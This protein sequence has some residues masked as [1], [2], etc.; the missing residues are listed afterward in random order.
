M[1]LGAL[2]PSM[3]IMILRQGMI[4]S[5]AGLALGMLA[6]A[7]VG[8]LVQGTFP[9]TGTDAVTFL[10][11]VPVVALVVMLATYIPARRA[12]RIDPLAA[13]RQE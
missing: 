7:A 11:I 5:V 8:G 9:G 12:A 3:L 13:L 10:L 1:A 2:P 4:P 6:S